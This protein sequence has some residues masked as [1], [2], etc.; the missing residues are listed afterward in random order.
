VTHPVLIEGTRVE[1]EYPELARVAR[2]E[3]SVVLQAVIRDDGTVG[4]LVVLRCSRP[5]MGFEQAAIEAVQQWRYK[6]G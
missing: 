1:P 3:A 2:V 4:D 5:N 6:P